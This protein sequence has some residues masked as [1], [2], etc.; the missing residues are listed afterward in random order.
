[1]TLKKLAVISGIALGIFILMVGGASLLIRYIISPDMVR[2]TVLPRVGKALQRH[3]EIGDV[4]IG[5]FKGISLRD[6][7]VFER[8]GKAVFVSLSGAHLRYQLLPL[9]SRRVVVD[10]I[11][12]DSPHISVVRSPDG[13]FNFSDL[14]KKGKPKDAAQKDKSPLSFAVARFSVTDGRVA[15]NDR[16]GLS[17]TPFTYE[18]S[19]IDVK[20]K[21]FTIE[22]AFPITLSAAIPGASLKFDGSVELAKNGPAVNGEFSI[23]DG[24]LASLVSGL[25]AGISGKV[26]KLSPTGEFTVKVRLAGGI[27][28]PFAM[29]QAGEIQLQE[30]RLAT[31]RLPTTLSGALLLS[32]GSLSSRDLAIDLGK[33]RLSLQLKTSPLDKKPLGIELSA[34]SGAIDLDSGATPGKGE[35][36]ARHPAPSEA[37]EAGP[38]NLPLTAG[39]SVRI[40]ALKYHGLTISGLSLRYRLENNNLSVDE[41]K[42][43]VAGGAFA[44]STRVNLAV[45]GFSYTT[46]LLLSGVQVDRLAN[47]FAPKASGSVTGILSARAELSGRGTIPAA[48]KRNLTGSGDFA[49]KNGKLSG[50]GFVSTL[51]GFLGS[52]E[53]RVVRFSTFNGTYRVGGEQVMLDAD[54]DGSDLKMKAKGR[55][56][57]D[58]SLDMAI[59]TRIA[60]RIT[61]KVA[62]G[63]V[64]SYVTDEQGWGV[65]PLQARGSVGSPRFSMSAAAIG[66][67]IKEK[68][69]EMI[70]KE[71][72]NRLNKKEGAG[73]QEQPLEKTIRGL[74]GN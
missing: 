10:E 59:D 36:G 18:I 35:K 38:L 48:M 67:R 13:T 5:I 32:G 65:L 3:I 8:D 30:I 7:K 69:G 42:G 27:K 56:G 55:I 73:Q 52:E 24:D 12:L 72:G 17:G 40:G 26:Q 20:A 21:D 49:I 71:L 25:P 19:A 6:L 58:R 2:K 23:G 50:S 22:R 43:S 64:G 68:A 37:K 11:V 33:N 54:L 1:M 34:S 51:A 41:L 74:F 4:R 14:L 16:K 47:A 70:R 61:G 46:R 66:R 31:G 62:Q 45:P 44:D 28:T 57:F 53:L 15:Y 39:G 29:L 60:P 9:L 63:T